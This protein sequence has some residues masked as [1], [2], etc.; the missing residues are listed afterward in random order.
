M[1]L[2]IKSCNY[3]EGILRS[4]QIHILHASDHCMSDYSNTGTLNLTAQPLPKCE[5]HNG[6][7]LQECTMTS[8][9]DDDDVIR[10]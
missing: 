2:G 7:G 10:Q 5:D 1:T 9:S 8:S 3:A 6:T 4:L